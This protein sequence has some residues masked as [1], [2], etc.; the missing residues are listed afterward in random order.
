MQT[1]I[2]FLSHKKYKKFNEL[3]NNA[4]GFGLCMLFTLGSTS[5]PGI[6]YDKT[7]YFMLTQ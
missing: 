3:L 4:F 2:I 5:A 7:S 1:A 6:K